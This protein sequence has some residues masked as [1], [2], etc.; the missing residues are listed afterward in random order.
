MK[1]RRRAGTVVHCDYLKK[2]H[3]SANRR[4]TDPV[5]TLSSIFESILNEMRDLPDVSTSLTSIPRH[6]ECSHPFA[7][8][9]LF[10]SRPSHSFS[11]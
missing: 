2:P 11:L 1:K 5:V 6:W 4:R 8:I 10:V 7:A 9:S 3:K